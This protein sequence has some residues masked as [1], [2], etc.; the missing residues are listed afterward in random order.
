[1]TRSLA[2]V[3]VLLCL[4]A[5]AAVPGCSADEEG[6]VVSLQTDFVPGVEIDAA[7]V[8]LD[9]AVERSVALAPRTSLSRPYR[10]TAYTMVL[11]GRRDVEVSLLSGG[12]VVAVRRVSVPF[13]RSRLVNVVI[14]RTCRG[15]VCGETQTCIAGTCESPRCETGTE[16]EC[17]RAQC[18]DASE[19]T[20]STAC[21]D[22]TCVAGICLEAGSEAGCSATQACVPGVGCVTLA[23]RD[24]GRFDGGAPLDAGPGMGLVCDPCATSSECLGGTA[25][26]LIAPGVRACVP[27]CTLE[28]P[29]CPGGFTCSDDGA[30]AFACVPTGG[31]CCLDE[32][33]DGYGMGRGCLGTDCA[34]DE[35]ARNPGRL[36]LCNGAD[37]DCDRIVDEPP[38]GCGAST[39]DP[40]GAA[41]TERAGEECREGACMPSGSASGCGLYTCSGGGDAGDVCA[42]S[43]ASAGG[44]DDRL[45]VT[46]AHCDGG[47]CAAD[48]GAGVG[49]DEDSDCATGRCQDGTCCMPGVGACACAGGPTETSCDDAADSD[50]DGATDCADSDCNGQSCGS[51]G[52]TCA[53]GVCACPG[54]A[55][56]ASCDDGA[57]DDCDGLIDCGDAD[58][59]ARTCGAS[60]RVCVGPS[61]ACPGGEVETECDDGADDDCDGLADCADPSCNGRT[62]GAARL[63][64]GTSCACAG[65]GS[66]T[67]CGNGTDDDCDGATDCADPDCTLDECGGGNRC[68]GTCTVVPPM[69][70]RYEVSAA[71]CSTSLGG[72]PYP[73]LCAL[74][75]FYRSQCGPLDLSSYA[76]G[77]THA[78]SSPAGCDFNAC[79]ASG[80]CQQNFCIPCPGGDCNACP[81]NPPVT[82]C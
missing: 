69:Y 48:A 65:G 21:V 13:V 55:A 79:D 67:V 39:C 82:P 80:A 41:F 10:L 38:V 14:S 52:Q 37:D 27:T 44:D 2:C 61:C 11:D 29:A 30:G 36:E 26:A 15:V 8:T 18:R 28:M 16:P 68:C 12:D 45:C 49:C 64:V 77:W 1:M 22:P 76:P 32:D 70:D 54:G 59:G 66:E 4:L 75:L 20:S 19:C 23:E 34:D 78:P 42:R 46:S 81:D 47:A 60:G 9:D 73:G 40:D 24:A 51:R 35:A 62:C 53:G 71:M 7:R 6:L 33:G 72:A 5:A 63:C 50:C 56:E 3:S 74:A 17:P 57:D 58:C 43:C 25:C 31:I